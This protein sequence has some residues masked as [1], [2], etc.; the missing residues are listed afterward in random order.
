MIDTI[1]QSVK[2]HD[3]H[4]VEVKLD[5]ELFSARKT[6][7]SVSTYIFVPHTL[8]IT[9]ESYARDLFYRDAQSY[10]RLKTPS[11]NLRE[12]AASE[13]SPLSRIQ[14]LI[15]NPSWI[16][17]A[18]CQEQLITQ[19]K[20]LSATF[21]SS[22]RDH[23]LFLQQRAAEGESG[24]YT[25]THTLIRNLVTEF[26]TETE[27]VLTTFRG[28]Y[29]DF[30]LPNVPEKVFM[31][32]AYTDE[33]LSIL[34]EECA[35]DLFLI[36]GDCFKR[37]ETESFQEALKQV[38]RRETKHRRARGYETLLSVD[39]DNER[40]LSQ[41]SRLKK[42]SDS[43]LY[44]NVG[45]QAE[46]TYLLQLLY[47]LA[48]GVAMI[49]ATALA[50][51]FQQQYGN[52]TLPFFIALVIGYMFK[53]RIK[54]LVRLIFARKLD[55]RL[56]DR[57]KKIFT[58]DGRHQLGVMK[59]KV[60]FINEADLPATVR[61]DRN[62]ENISNPF[63][64]GLAENIICY[65]REIT[66]ECDTFASVFPDFPA[67]TGVNDIWRYDIRHFLYRMA[68]SEQERLLFH[69]DDLIPVTGQK[70]YHVNVISRFRLVQPESIKQNNRLRLV[71]TRQG[72]KRIEEVP[73]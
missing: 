49:F 42:Y 5:Y 1:Q 71:L 35:A 44:L 19:F 9:S 58:Q 73:G 54:D 47:A 66:L 56:Y 53:D 59:E 8:G 64:E 7:Y 45:V 72:I 48:A 25:K 61:R 22:L 28:L 62:R 29:A 15:G 12:F 70:V 3:T 67:I 63:E 52:L 51:F 39:G 26:L 2:V 40:Y 10:I 38:A 36:V 18:A 68:G 55:E 27:A 21:N 50:F 46:G 14:S 60:R 33:S 31:A 16:V 34:V 24:E 17:D 65:S 13:R 6:K 37:K 69:A 57:R 30:N 41:V 20:L 23:H 4:Q 43:V 11:L 32:Y